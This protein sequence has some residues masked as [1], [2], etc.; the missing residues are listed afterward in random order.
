MEAKLILREKIPAF[1]LPSTSLKEI[2]LWDYDQKKNLLIFFFHGASCKFCLGILKNLAASYNELRNLNCEVLAI[3]NAILEELSGIKNL[4]G[5]P[6]PIISDVNKRYIEKF[7]YIDE[8]SKLV[9][10]VFVVDKYGILFSQY[11][12]DEDKREFDLRECIDELSFIESQCE[13]CGH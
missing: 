9:A 8:R 6:F 3:S 1:F 11:F 4:L 13:E 10:S 5:I 12:I 2:S 7:T